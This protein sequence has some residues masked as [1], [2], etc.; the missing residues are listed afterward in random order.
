MNW[1][2]TYKVYRFIRQSRFAEALALDHKNQYVNPAWLYYRLGMYETAFQQVSASDFQTLFAKVVSAANIGLHNESQFHLN[3]LSDKFSNKVHL[4]ASPLATY[5]PYTALKIL[6]KNHLKQN[7]LYLALLN[8]LDSSETINFLKKNDFSNLI[9]NSPDA[10]LLKANIQACTSKEKLNMLNDYLNFFSLSSINIKSNEDQFNINNLK[11]KINSQ[12][13]HKDYP[14]VSIIV[15]T[16]NIEDRVEASL[17]S[18]IHQTYPN[19]E[20]IVVDDASTDQTCIKIENLSQK[21]SQIKLIK[22]PINVG[23]F[24][25]KTIGAHHAKG[26]FITCQDADDWAHPQR[27]FN[28]IMPLLKNKKLVASTCQWVRLSDHGQFYARQVFPL[29]RFNPSSPLFRKKEVLE[30]TGLWDLTRLAADTE[31]ITRLKLVFGREK[32]ISI[33][34]PLVI[35]AHRDNSLM[36]AFETGNLENKISPIRLKYWESWGYWHIQQ[37]RKNAPLVMPSL[38]DYSPPFDAPN[39]IVN[40]SQSLHSLKH[41]F[42]SIDES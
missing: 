8:N 12:N 15:P 39:E 25:A 21:Y 14:C 42:T 26:E 28:Q 33:K 36:T 5:A 31:F 2:E 19:I 22:L 11:S 41:F 34:Q 40:T 16:Y 37:L 13:K 3:E 27:I 32:I 20:L 24:V 10:L 17:E 9:K 4:L 18:L 38:F 7:N 6:H 23:P 29:T 30:K 1:F 35:G